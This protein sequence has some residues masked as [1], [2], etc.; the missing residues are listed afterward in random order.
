MFG[1]ELFAAPVRINFC[2]RTMKP[3]PSNLSTRAWLLMVTPCILLAYPVLRLVLPVLLRALT[4][5]V[6]RNVLNAI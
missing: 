1:M 5:E 2:E 6:L 4:P 3:P